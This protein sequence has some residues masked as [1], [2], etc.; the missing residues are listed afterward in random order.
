MMSTMCRWGLALFAAA[1]VIT[2]E[3]LSQSTPAPEVS[4]REESAVFRSKVTLI[5]VP[6]VVR[7]KNG[8]PIGT[9]RQE[10]F[11]LFDKG[12][13][14]IISRFSVE[15]SA[16]G[17]A[18]PVVSVEGQTPDRKA[19]TP[20]V[21]APD[22]FVGLLFDDVHTNFANQVQAKV[23]AQKFVAS[24]LRS[25]DR[26]AIFTTSGQLAL[27]FTDDRDLLDKTL[28]K[29]APHPLSSVSKC[30]EISL[31]QADLITNTHDA[32]A[33]GVA[34]ADYEKC[35]PQTPP[36][37]TLQAVMGLARQ[38]YQQGRQ[39]TVSTIANIRT[40]IGKMA[41]MPGQRTL[42]LASPGFH[43]MDDQ[44]DQESSVI[45]LAIRSGVV[46]NGLDVQGLVAPVTFDAENP[47]AGPGK[48]KLNT[49]AKTAQAGVLEELTSGTGGKLVQNANDLF[50][51]LQKLGAAPE[52]FYLLGFSP[53]N[54]KLDGKFHSLKVEVKT[55]A[56]LSPAELSVDARRGYYAPTHLATAGR[57]RK[58][59]S[60]RHC[61]RRMKRTTSRSR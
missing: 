7:D 34:V 9:L 61:S 40:V 14:Q 53:Q 27:D 28:Q 33:I 19:A 48:E 30:P 12:K 17:K 44:H 4:T 60:A 20:P 26:A 3:P 13:P 35:Y 51:G 45:D 42:I 36:Q 54:L 41:E 25:N 57:T 56:G 10:D 15:K 59:R 22:H 11:Q 23:A 55:P 37:V 32:L 31:Y 8:Q 58:K 43:L 50:A 1:L 39:E 46:I 24:N 29:L 47:G 49:M 52:V 6:V 16:G 18:I 5:E 2:A 21:V 38:V